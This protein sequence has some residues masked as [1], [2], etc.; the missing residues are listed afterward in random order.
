MDFK[1]FQVWLLLQ[2]IAKSWLFDIK[3]YFIKIYWVL[4]VF[5]FEVGGLQKV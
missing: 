1:I 4:A 2:I 3:L 5:F